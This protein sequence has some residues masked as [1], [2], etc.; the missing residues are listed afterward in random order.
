MHIDNIVSS[1]VLWKN[2]QTS[3]AYRLVWVVYE[4]NNTKASK[5]VIEQLCGEDALGVEKW[6]ETPMTPWVL[7]KDFAQLLMGL[8]QQ[9][10][11]LETFLESLP[12][13]PEEK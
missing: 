10:T 5:A 1:T 4:E 6:E 12:G 9:R 3:T 2:D 8:T 13:N 7:T 11:H